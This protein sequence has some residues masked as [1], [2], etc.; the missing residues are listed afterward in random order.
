MKHIPYHLCADCESLKNLTIKSDIEVIAGGAFQFTGIKEITFPNTLKTIGPSSFYSSKIEKLVID[1][2]IE[3]IG[4]Y[5]FAATP[6]KEVTFK[7]IKNLKLGIQSFN[8]KD[9]CTV[10]IIASKEKARQFFIKNKNAFHPRIKINI[11]EKTLDD[12]IKENQDKDNIK[13]SKASDLE[14]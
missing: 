7:N 9:P 1:E 10:N 5:A 13:E 8:S 2:N 11:I 6:L 3:E 14:R 4:D 12:C